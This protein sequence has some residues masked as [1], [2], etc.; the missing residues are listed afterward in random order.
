VASCCCG[1]W[2]VRA[3]RQPA[4]RSQPHMPPPLLPRQLLRRGAS[5]ARRPPKPSCSRCATSVP[6]AGQRRCGS[7]P[8]AGCAACTCG[9][10]RLPRR[11][12]CSR[13][14]HG[15]SSSSRQLRVAVHDS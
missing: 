3:A 4:E 6:A 2:G 13:G 14:G 15:S 12:H 7:C 9:S 10:F 1:A 5:C 8:A 11:C